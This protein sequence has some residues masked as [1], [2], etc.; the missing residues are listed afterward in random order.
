MLG[1]FGGPFVV[2]VAVSRHVRTSAAIIPNGARTL[3]VPPRVSAGGW[4][5]APTALRHR[6]PSE[7]IQT[8]GRQ[9]R[10]GRQR[11]INVF[12]AASGSIL[13]QLPSELVYDN[14]LYHMHYSRVCYGFGGPGGKPCRPCGR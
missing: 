10:L 7:T 13:R 2:V 14:N 11:G 1:E 9:P 5:P 3:L 12:I 4:R 6:E 8:R